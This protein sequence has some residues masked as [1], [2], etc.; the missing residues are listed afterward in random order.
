M[1][2]TPLPTGLIEQRLREQIPE[3]EEVLGAAE[4]SQVR[5][6][7][8]FR[9]GTAYVVLAAERNPAGSGGQPQRRAASESVFGVIVCAR[10]YRGGAGAAALDEC[11]TLVGLVRDA[12]LGWAMPG[13][14]PCQWL[15]GN[16]LDSDQSRVLWV[17]V[18]TTTHVLGGTP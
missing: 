5:D 10:N 3:L 7:A 16:V 13:A 12:L 18:F 4:Y 6:L 17:D 11:A 14:K 15:Q 1:S 8:G 9:T 2:C